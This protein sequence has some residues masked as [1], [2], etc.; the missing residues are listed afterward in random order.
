MKRSLSKNSLILIGIVCGLLLATAFLAGCTSTAPQSQTPP[1][2]P[3]PTPQP[4]V[5]T[6]CTGAN[7]GCC[8]HGHAQTHVYPVPGQCGGVHRSLS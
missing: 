7:T 4:A 5:T 1:A 6:D 2:T 8:D 3:A